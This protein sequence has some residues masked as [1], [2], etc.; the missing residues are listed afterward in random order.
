MPGLSVLKAMISVPFEGN[1]A[2]SRRTGL[3]RF[4]FE[5]ISPTAGC[6]TK[7]TSF[8]CARI[9]KSCP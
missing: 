4:K 8:D 9:T 3:V 6:G 7:F 1:T 5:G 2:T